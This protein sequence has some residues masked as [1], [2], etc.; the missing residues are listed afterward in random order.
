M[1]EALIQNKKLKKK[2][3]GHIYFSS[4]FSSG[5]F[6]VLHFIL[7]YVIQFELNFCNV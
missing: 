3:Q 1:R 4:L 2:W 6:G 5:S 7:R